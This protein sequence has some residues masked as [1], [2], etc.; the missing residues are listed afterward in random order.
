MFVEWDRN[1][2]KHN[3][4]EDGAT[5]HSLGLGSE[6]KVDFVIVQSTSK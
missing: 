6:M 3:H 2:E 5:D 1:K 4:E